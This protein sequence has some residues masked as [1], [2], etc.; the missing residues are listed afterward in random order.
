MTVKLYSYVVE[1]DYGHSPNPEKGFCTLVHCKF[2]VSGKRRNIVELAN[3]GDWILGTGGS[4]RES[5]GHGKIVY[6]MRVDEILPF[7]EFMTDPR[8]F[9]RVDRYD[10]GNNNTLALISQN[11]YYFGEN[12]IDIPPQFHHLQIEKRGPGYRYDLS[13]DNVAAFIS[14][15]QENKTMG[16]LG[17]P[18]F[19]IDRTKP[20][21]PDCIPPICYTKCRKTTILK[22]KRK[23][24]NVC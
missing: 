8:F 10:E 14:W 12:A 20:K 3:K 17:E 2:N 11:F 4:S 7:S 18:T 9:G 19:P 13:E 15:F 24:Y 23:L 21:Q 6:F 5:A 22:S 16:K 1:H